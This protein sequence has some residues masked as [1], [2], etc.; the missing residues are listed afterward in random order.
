MVVL[1]ELEKAVVGWT[2]VLRKYTEDGEWGWKN[3]LG[4][5]LGTI[6]SNYLQHFQAIN[7]RRSIRT[8]SCAFDVSSIHDPLRQ[9]LHHG[10]SDP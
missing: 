4:L 3:D 5:F 9:A 2:D 6:F 7:V 10:N 8:C 1:L